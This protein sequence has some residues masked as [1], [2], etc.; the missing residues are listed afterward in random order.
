V[1]DLGS[2]LSELESVLDRVREGEMV[3]VPDGALDS[4][5]RFG[6]GLNRTFGPEVFTGVDRLERKIDEQAAAIERFR[7][8][9]QLQQETLRALIEG[10]RSTVQLQQETLRAFVDHA[11]ARLIDEAE[12]AKG[13]K[14]R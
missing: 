14:K 12:P 4:L 7:S 11:A 10:L 9:V 5:R 6:E 8:M 2:L 3:E 1:A 13:G